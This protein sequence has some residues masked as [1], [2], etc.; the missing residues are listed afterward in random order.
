MSS[1]VEVNNLS[2]LNAHKK[3]HGF[4]DTPD[5]TCNCT[6][7]AES[8]RHFPCFRSIGYPCSITF[9]VLLKYEMSDFCEDVKVIQLYGNKMFTLAENQTLLLV[10]IEFI[11]KT[12]RF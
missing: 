8:T 5:E 10:T 4:I 12:D 3:S 11:G 2:P 7:A 1:H 9:E 6:L